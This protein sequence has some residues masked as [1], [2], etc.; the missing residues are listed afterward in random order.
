MNTERGITVHEKCLSG[1]KSLP[2]D[3]NPAEKDPKLEQ[4]KLETTVS[5]EQPPEKG[6]FVNLKRVHFALSS[7]NY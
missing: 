6:R 4:P 2:S 7:S 3:S 1:I 5:K